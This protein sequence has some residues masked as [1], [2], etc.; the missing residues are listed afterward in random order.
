VFDDGLGNGGRHERLPE[1]RCGSN[2]GTQCH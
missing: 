2:I 1:D